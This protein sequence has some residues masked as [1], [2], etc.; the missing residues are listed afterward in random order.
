MSFYHISMAIWVYDT[1]NHTEKFRLTEKALKP[2]WK[3]LQKTIALILS[4]LSHWNVSAIVI[5]KRQS[6]IIPLNISSVS[7]ILCFLFSVTRFFQ[8]YF[9]WYIL[10]V[11]CDSYF[12]ERLKF[13]TKLRLQASVYVLRLPSQYLKIACSCSSV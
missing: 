12:E 6:L 2:H 5:Q 8:C 3:A 7:H 11:I 4:L 9:Q 1:E 10:Q 13:R